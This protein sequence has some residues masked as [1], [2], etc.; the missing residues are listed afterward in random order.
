MFLDYIHR[1]NADSRH[2][3]VRLTPSVERALERASAR[4]RTSHQGS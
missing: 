4:P 3:R 1:S 2:G